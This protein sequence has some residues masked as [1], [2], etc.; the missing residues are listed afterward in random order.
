MHDQRVCPICMALE[1]YTWVFETGKDQL[2]GDLIH[3]DF[4]LVWNVQS[5]SEAHGHHSGTCRCH[6]EPQ[7]DFSDLT[8]RAQRLLAVLQSASEIGDAK[9]DSFNES[10]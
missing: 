4:G 1:G 3:P 7:F 9:G 5:G 10:G 2:N 8:E 6:M